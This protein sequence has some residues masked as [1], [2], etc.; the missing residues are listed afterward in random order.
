MTVG[1]AG[2]SIRELSD[3]LK[4]VEI[5]KFASWAGTHSVM[6]RKA[7]AWINASDEESCLELLNDV[8]R[9]MEKVPRAYPCFIF[10]KTF[11]VTFNTTPGLCRVEVQPV[12]QDNWEAEQFAS[13]A[14]LDLLFRQ[15]NLPIADP[16]ANIRSQLFEP[17]RS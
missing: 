13:L 9:Q 17:E 5:F 1:F 2:F 3:Y 11:Y 12:L 4:G 7:Y 15:L 16:P 10:E 6:C 14:R 8:L